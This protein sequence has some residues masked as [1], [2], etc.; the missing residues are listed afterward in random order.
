M[1]SFS[2]FVG[3]AL[4]CLGLI[5]LKS[6]FFKFALKTTSLLNAMLDYES[7]ENTKHR[8]LIR[9]L[10]AMLPLFFLVLLGLFLSFLVGYLPVLAFENMHPNQAEPSVWKALIGMMAGSIVLFVPGWIQKK[11]DYSD[12]GRL[13]HRILLDNRF[14]NLFLF[15][16]DKRMH[17]KRVRIK[18][19]DFVLVTGLAR[20]GTT[21]IT[22]LLYQSDKFHSLTYRNMPFI[23]APG[24]RF[25]SR[26][27]ATLKERA[28]GDHLMVGVDSVEALEE[29]FFY[30][31]NPHP[32]QGESVKSYT[33]TERENDRYIQYQNL[34]PRRG[35]TTRY[36][37]KNNNSII[38]LSELINWNPSSKVLLMFRHPMEQASSLHAQH[39]RFIFKQDQDGFVLEYMNWLKHFEFGKGHKPF[40]LGEHSFVSKYSSSTL[41]YWLELWIYYY[42]Y[43]LQFLPHPQILP[44]DYAEFLAEPNLVRNRVTH[45]TGEVLNDKWPTFQTA[46]KVFSNQV[47]P[48]IEKR[49][50]AVYQ[51]LQKQ[52]GM[53]V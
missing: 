42:E 46:T 16:L 35:S 13:L 38:R 20:A 5:F 28:H 53:A 47:D 10:G 31:H 21:A 7:D 39:E 29:P 36:L 44:I 30:Y 50:K 2:V 17:A 14:I 23:L 51:E 34:I 24:F 9:K 22:N 33:L 32:Y 19:D 43:A 37:S 4:F 45:F 25:G 11:K 6:A 12:W 15:Q 3:T 49:A 52:T 48:V 27:K 41:N 8:N 26:Q 40:H 1:Y 18:R